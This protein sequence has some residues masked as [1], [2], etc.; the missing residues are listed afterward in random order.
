MGANNARQTGALAQL[1]GVGEKDTGS[2]ISTDQHAECTG[3]VRRAVNSRRAGTNRKARARQ[4]SL[5]GVS[6]PFS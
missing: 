4:T 5:A 6:R 3:L 1:G 2:Q